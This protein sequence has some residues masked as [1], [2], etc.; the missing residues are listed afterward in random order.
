MDPEIKKKLMASLGTGALVLFT[1]STISASPLII[2]ADSRYQVDLSKFSRSPIVANQKAGSA[3]SGV[4]WR[5]GD[6]GLE[7]CGDC[8]DGPIVDD[9]GDCGL[10]DCGDCVDEP[11]GNDCMAPGADDCDCMGAGWECDDNPGPPAKVVPA[12]APVPSDCA[13]PVECDPP[14][15]CGDCGATECDCS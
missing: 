8:V 13:Q 1:S 2:G 10:E 7:D 6:C 11:T 5:A 14:S 3:K 9:C 12:P 15:D 4:H